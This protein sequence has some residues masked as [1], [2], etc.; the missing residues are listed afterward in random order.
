MSPVQ[1]D[2]VLVNLDPT[3]GSEMRKTRPCVVLSPDEL[4]RHL[5]T[6]TIAPMTTTGKP[7]PTRVKVRQ[8]RKNGWVVVDQIRTI[9]RAR[10]VR[11]LGHLAPKE[12]V[13]LKQVIKETFVD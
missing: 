6:V 7:Y 10:I 11:V 5:Q 9:D 4:N 3:M 2:V 1:Y 8:D 12:V 13:L